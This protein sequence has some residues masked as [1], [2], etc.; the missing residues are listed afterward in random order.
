M[1]VD[2]RTLVVSGTH[3]EGERLDAEQQFEWFVS[4]FF[5][6]ERV[7]VGCARNIDA[8]ARIFFTRLL[9]VDCVEMK[10][11]K[12]RVDGVFNPTAG[13]VRNLDM[14]R[15]APWN[16]HLLA[17]PCLLPCG[18]PDWKR[19]PGTKHCFDNAQHR[20]FVHWR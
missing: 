12:W 10:V 13:F 2:I 7:I 3:L 20:L 9:G 5:R 17:I 11:A 6:P 15:A 18:M 16:G 1:R 4:T 8:R 14:I 19:S